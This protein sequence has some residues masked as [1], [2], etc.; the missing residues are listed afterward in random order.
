MIHPISHR[1]GLI[2]AACLA[3]LVPA[4]NE[5]GGKATEQLMAH[6]RT[7]SPGAEREARA[8]QAYGQLPLNFEANIGQ[9]KQR[10]G[11]PV[12]YLSRGAGYTLFLTGHE[13]V[14]ALRN[15]LGG[16]DNRQVEG[17]VKATSLET[18]LRD[19]GVHEL[20]SRGDSLRTGDVLRMK[21]VDSNAAARAEGEDESAGR[22]NYFL[23]K[24]SAVWRKDIP[25]YARVKYHDVYPGIDLV[26][27][28]NQQQLEY[29]FVVAPG[30]NPS[31]IALDVRAAREG[32]RT[33]HPDAR[34]GIDARGD[35]VIATRGG[36]VRFHKPVVYQLAAAESSNRSSNIA[37]R[38]S[39]KGRYVLKGKHEV[40]FELAAYDP[41]RPLVIDPVLSYSTYLGGTSGADYGQAIALDPAGNAYVTGYTCSTDF[42]TLDPV[43]SLNS[44]G[45]CEDAFVAKLDAAGDALV[46]STYLGGAG[47]DVGL[48]I[49]VDPAG[50]AYVAGYTC[51]T[52]FPVVNPIQATS[53][54]DCDGFVS[55]L[56][57][58]GDA[59]VYSTYLGGSNTDV[60]Q[61][62]R[63]DPAGNAYV[64]GYTLSADFPTTTGAFQSTFGGGSCG[65]APP[66]EATP[67][68]DAFVAKLNPSG[69]ALVYSTYLGG[70]SYDAG[71]GI[72]VDGAGNAYVTGFTVST[73]FPTANALQSSCNNCSLAGAV[74]DQGVSSDAF[75]TKLNPAGSA[76]VYSTYLGGSG[77]DTGSGIAV[78]P[79]GSAYVTGYTASKDFPTMNPLQPEHA[80][81]YDAFVAKLGADGSA[82]VYSTYL[83]GSGNDLG[84]A[85]AVDPAG[86][87]TIVGETFSPDFPA[88]D[89]FQPGRDGGFDAFVSRLSAVGD[90][91]VYSSYLGGGS[92][93]QALG[94]ALDFSGSVYV[95]GITNSA[96]YPTTSVAYQTTCEGGSACA[97]AGAKAYVVKIDSLDVPSAALSTLNLEFG[98]ETV[99]QASSAQ[100]VTLRNV[101]SQLLVIRKI[102]TASRRYFAESNDCG[103]QLAPGDSCTINVTFTPAVTGQVTGFLVVTDNSWPKG[104]QFVRLAG[105]G[106]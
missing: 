103:A 57:S 88:N 13:A 97:E 86:S 58:A 10:S 22:S 26:Y 24:D 62:I 40:G 28:G 20:P 63:A 45:G 96:D 101:G 42:P 31:L 43:Q 23:G 78:D 12:K 21:L 76:L 15:N 18:G 35:L 14:L 49:A 36:S 41:S 51:S 98:A 59:L 104:L 93:D 46:Y 87:V 79:A 8:R 106:T 69:S 66:G 60:A 100:A 61:A 70:S 16:E 19:S 37:N 54:G 5:P 72:G 33:A 82:L 75:V 11:T 77:A 91:L 34:L 89:A 32:S 85:I 64:T 48:G 3:V 84:F 65:A 6:F 50:R 53:S 102:F 29:D 83:G 74:A 94:V 99:D 68:A 92:G 73:N 1:T 81:G 17:P 67:C 30:A 9:V 95:T 38:Q 2:L 105:S 4:A 47:N 80:G 52:D 90:A 27:Y 25:N 7:D 39:V 56:N 71:Q 44:S 55:K